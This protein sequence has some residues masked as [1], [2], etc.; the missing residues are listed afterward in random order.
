MNALASLANA[1][2][3]GTQ[4]RP[5]TWP[6]LDGPIGALLDRI[7]RDP[8]ERALLQ[9]AAVLG[10]CHLAGWLPA[11]VAA[12]PPPAADE[13]TEQETRVGLF[14]AILSEGPLR[15]QAEAFQR[16]ADAGR[17]L[18]H[19]V[20]PQ[21]LECGRRNTAL[22]PSLRGVLGRRGVWLA[23]QN[24]D[25]AYAAS[26]PGPELPDDDVWLHGSLDQRRLY[27]SALR[28]RDAARARELVAAA[29]GEE[30][31]RER[32]AW[33][34]CLVTGLTLDDQDLLETALTDRSKEV[35]QTAARLLVSL[36]GSRY[37]DRMAQ[38]LQSCLKAEKKLLRGAVVTVEAPAAFVPAWKADG[39]EANRPKGHRLGDRA[40][41][42]YQLVRS[43][44]LAW[45]ESQTG[46][47]PV[48]LLAWARKSD[49]KDAL[50]DGWAEAQAAQR[51]VE[52][53]EAFLN[54][55]GPGHGPLNVFDLLETLPPPVREQHF[56]RLL[57]A[58][59]SIA[60][61]NGVLDGFLRGWPLDAPPLTPETATKVVKFLQQRALRGGARPD[62]QTRAV[63]VELACVLPPAV[64]DE[65]EEGWDSNLEHFALLMDAI[66]RIGIVLDQRR[67]ILQL[68]T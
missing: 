5:P 60:A 41:W 31:A 36:P 29:L 49:W 48:E 39:L 64:F 21:A 44:P 50:L 58:A 54:A 25:W 10:T 63:L 42:L 17:H 46:M 40:W 35:R 14:A 51:R 34:E 45:W 18:P 16:L 55:P 43:A 56:L 33:I 32:A 62:A 7:P 28:G 68:K 67:Q 19:R 9:T 6:A 53:A 11:E 2:L 61:I 38:H 24:E 30:T 27:L 22:R 47:S 13:T 4:R 8:P 59:S 65:F 20:L 57:V 66:A 23:A 1:A 3:L 15:L 26:T 37:A 12:V 52:W